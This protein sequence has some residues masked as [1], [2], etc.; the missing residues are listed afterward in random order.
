MTRC[1]SQEVSGRFAEHYRTLFEHVRDIVL[2]IEADTG[3]IIDAIHAVEL[4]FRCTRE[5]LLTMSSYELRTDTNNRVG[6]QMQA[7]DESGTLF[8]TLHKRCD[9]TTFPVEVSSRGETIDNQR[10]L[11]SIIRD[12]TSRRQLEEL[13]DEFLVLASH[14]KSCAGS[15]TS[16]TR[17]AMPRS[18]AARSS[19]CA[20]CATSVRS[21]ARASSASAATPSGSAASSPS[22]RCPSPAAG[23]AR[24]SSRSSRT[25]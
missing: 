5:Q 10:L 6:R 7:A 24:A 21:S 2:M 14:A 13:R 3:M 4:A 25:S 19:G 8:E 9:G 1:T 17:C 18:R 20:R 15:R 11:L 12:I 16:S 23:I 22:R